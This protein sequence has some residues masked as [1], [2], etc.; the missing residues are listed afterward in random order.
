M[1]SV[2]S[3]N[4]QR[5][6]GRYRELAQREPVVITSHG[7]ES[8]VPLSAEEYRRLKRLDREALYPGELDEAD[9]TALS[10]A[11]APDEAGGCERSS[12]LNDARRNQAPIP[13][14]RRSPD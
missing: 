4:F 1:A 5:G 11:C 9:V 3:D 2:T 13:I 14:G 10:H 8:F 7:R 12:A 6:L